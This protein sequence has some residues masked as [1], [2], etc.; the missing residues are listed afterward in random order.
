MFS[1]RHKTCLDNDGRPQ[2]DDS[3]N[4]GCTKGDNTV[5]CQGSTHY[6]VGN[7][8][9]CGRQTG[10]GGLVSTLAGKTPSV[11][12]TRHQ[13]TA[14]CDGKLLCV[15]SCGLNSQETC[16]FGCIKNGCSSSCITCSPGTNGVRTIRTVVKAKTARA[17]Y[18]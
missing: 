6:C 2:T 5:Y 9:S 10:K 4:Y 7:C 8:Q 13:V 15:K 14:V 18:R 16:G 1:D 17:S 3:G 12:L 11:S